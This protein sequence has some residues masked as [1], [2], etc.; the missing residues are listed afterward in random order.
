VKKHERI[1]RGKKKAGRENQRDGL[2][3][4]AESR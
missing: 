2:A 4:G 1:K 3:V